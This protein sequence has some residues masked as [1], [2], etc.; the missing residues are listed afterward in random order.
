MTLKQI[1]I[2]NMKE[3]RKK[4]G[5]SQMK[6]AE[7]CNTSSTYIGEIEVGKKFPS[8]DM[9]EKISSILKI[10]PYLFFIERTNE[11]TDNNFPK[12]PNSMKKEINNKLNLSINDIINKILNE[13]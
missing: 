3:F 8:M 13:Y 10:K 9:I 5:I 7:L 2:E 4:E 11:N 1:F 12:L 6:L